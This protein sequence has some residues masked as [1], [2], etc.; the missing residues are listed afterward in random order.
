MLI[1]LIV[2]LLVVAG[3]VVALRL[4]DP[5]SEEAEA[6]PA[7][8]ET[9][10]QAP[11]PTPLVTPMPKLSSATPTPAA[12]EATPA[13]E[14]TAA[15]ALAAG[16]PCTSGLSSAIAAA[17]ASQSAFMRGE[18]SADQLSASWGDLAARAQA[19]GESLLAKR[20][21]AYSVVR[22]TAIDPQVNNCTILSV[23]DDENEVVVETQEVWTYDAVLSCTASDDEQTSR[24]LVTY[25][26]QQ[27]TFARDGDGWRMQGWNIGVVNIEPAWACT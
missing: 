6:T 4:T 23:S 15:P 26:G 22:I 18:S 3:T 12:S 27:Y 17:N 14:A 25:P 9:S 5:G 20:T 11:T 7:P 21:D 19:S 1:I 8:Q 24:E 10:Q 13:P 2:V 16:D